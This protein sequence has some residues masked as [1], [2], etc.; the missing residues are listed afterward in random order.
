MDPDLA[1]RCSS[2][3]DVTMA[4]GSRTGHSDLH[5]PAEAWPLE[6]APLLKAVTYVT[7]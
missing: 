5:G 4:S 2:D 7:G 3:P 1:L 6:E